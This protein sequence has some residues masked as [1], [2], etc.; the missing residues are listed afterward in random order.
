MALDVTGILD[1][2]VSHAQSL[3]LFET[4][5]RHQPDNAPGNGLTC[6]VTV[7]EIGPVPGASGLNSTTARVALNVMVFA[8]VVQEPA[9]DIEPVVIGAVDALFTE[10]SGDFT[11]GDEVRNVDLLGAHG[12]PLSAQTG[13]VTI[14]AQTYR[15]AII[16]LPL[17]VN[18]LWSQAP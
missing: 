5:N 16:T 13:Y 12:T 1:A 2:V 17:V 10:Y 11:L 7:A 9:D 14:D 6:A 18:D 8:P 4:V 3:G 15:V